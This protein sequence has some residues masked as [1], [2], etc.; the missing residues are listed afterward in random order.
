MSM[1]DRKM[2]GKQAVVGG[3][4]LN[5]FVGGSEPEEVKSV[6]PPKP[7]S[8]PVSVAKQSNP[9]DEVVKPVRVAKIGPDKLKENL[10]ERVQIRLT[11]TEMDKLA[12]PM[13][14]GIGNEIVFFNLKRL[15][16]D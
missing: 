8:K 13:E 10:T 15:E 4:D 16:C 1:T 12:I 14:C 6:E 5:S 9:L 3:F 7:A 11:K 2:T